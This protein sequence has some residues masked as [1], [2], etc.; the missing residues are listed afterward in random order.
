MRN[1]FEKD[2]GAPHPNYK[3]KTRVFIRIRTFMDGVK[4]VARDD[5]SH[6]LFHVLRLFAYLLDKDSKFHGGGSHFHIH[7]F[8]A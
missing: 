1:A 4:V 2:M 7:R 6:E 5:S 8:G 3:A